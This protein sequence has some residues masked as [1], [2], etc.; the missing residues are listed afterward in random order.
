MILMALIL[1]PLALVLLLACTNV[2]MLFLSPSIT[3]RGEIAIRLALGAG[4]ARL[5][6]MLALE[7]F[8][9]AAAAGLASIYLAA[10]F[11]FLL[12]SFSAIDPATAAVA[13]VTIG[14]AAVNAQII[15]EYGVGPS[16]LN[17]NCSTLFA[18]SLVKPKSAQRWTL[19]NVA[20]EL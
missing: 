13:S 18:N 20:T 4:R 17:A 7:S 10:R 1:G 19:S 15:C 14:F 9:T 12:F 6:R 3:R 5:I 11:P 16:E 8:F 2:S